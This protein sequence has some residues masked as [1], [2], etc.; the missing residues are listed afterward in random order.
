MQIAVHAFGV[1]RQRLLATT[2]AVDLQSRAVY[3]AYQI[4]PSDNQTSLPKSS[5]ADRPAIKT[6]IPTLDIKRFPPHFRTTNTAR[7]HS[8][9]TQYPAHRVLS[10]RHQP[11]IR[12][13]S[14]CSSH[15]IRGFPADIRPGARQ[16]T[17]HF[18]PVVSRARVRPPFRA[19]QRPASEAGVAISQAC[20]EMKSSPTITSPL[21][22]QLDNKSL[23]TTLTAALTSGTSPRAVQVEVHR[24]K[25]RRRCIGSTPP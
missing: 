25:R 9:T 5:P 20:R 6:Q 11:R 1:T 14:D 18:R 16:I 2:N 3:A 24:D 4:I 12:Q 19:P 23:P 22:F 15:S 21:S 13:V 10:A 17:G 8:R 7:T